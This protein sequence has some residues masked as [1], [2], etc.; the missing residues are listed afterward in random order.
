MTELEKELI[1]T[2]AELWPKS[3]LYLFKIFILKATE[4]L[5]RYLV[6]VRGLSP[7]GFRCA[8][9]KTSFRSPPGPVGSACLSTGTRAPN[10][11]TSVK[12]TADPY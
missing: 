8:L 2:A 3:K 12:H 10:Y 11:A 4:D 7:H 1:G 9:A 5:T 6:V